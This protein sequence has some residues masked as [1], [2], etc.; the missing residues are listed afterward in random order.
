M[1]VRVRV[2]ARVRARARARVRVS[3]HTPLAAGG[4]EHPGDAAEGRAEERAHGNA[5]DVQV[6]AAGEPGQV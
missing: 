5:T 4:E 1:R 6:A 3:S 2:R